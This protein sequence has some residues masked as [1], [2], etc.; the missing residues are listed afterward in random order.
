ML[1]AEG[2]SPSKE[3]RVQSLKNII[4]PEKYNGVNDW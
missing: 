4:V 3:H 2:K 1:N